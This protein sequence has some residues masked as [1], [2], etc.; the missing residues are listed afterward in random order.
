VFGR[1][2]RYPADNLN[3]LFLAFARSLCLKRGRDTFTLLVQQKA[4]LPYVRALAA[5]YKEFAG[6]QPVFFCNVSQWRGAM[7]KAD[8]VLSARIHGTAI[9]IA[10]EA[11][12]FNVAT[13]MRQVEFIQRLSLPGVDYLHTSLRDDASFASLVERHATN[14]DAA[15]FNRNRAKLAAGYSRAFAAAAIPLNPKVAAL[16]AGAARRQEDVSAGKQIQHSHATM[17]NRYPHVYH[18]VSRLARSTHWAGNRPAKILSFGSSTGKEAV[19]LARRYFPRSQIVGVDIDEA[20]LNEA[21]ATCA[22]Y[23]SRVTFFNGKEQPLS[24]HGT[25]DV[26]F[27]N[28]VLTLYNKQF[29]ASRIPELYPFHNFEEII[30]KLTDVLQSGGLLCIVNTNYRLE[31]TSFAARFDLEPVS[32]CTNFVPLFD[33]N[34]MQLPIRDVC[35]YRKRLG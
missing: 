32:G 12:T 4:D 29:S 34:G 33:K 9:S 26:I 35:V 6:V 24:A 7:A 11:P 8:L 14:F 10:G 5:E 1:S 30:G 22:N 31:D 3:R 21:R 2:W 25:Y 18:E 20:T 15:S 19:T 16:A 23:S 17:E 27:A 13:D 28:S